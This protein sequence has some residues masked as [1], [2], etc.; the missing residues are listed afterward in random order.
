MKIINNRKKTLNEV[1]HGDLIELNNNVCLV[2][3]DKG[4]KTTK[5]ARLKDGVIEEYKNDT[6]VSEMEGVL[7]IK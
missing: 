6:I 1:W 4:T 5:L 2:I 7:K 3:G